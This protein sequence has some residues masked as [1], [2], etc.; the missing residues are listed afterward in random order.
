MQLVSCPRRLP[1]LLE[2]EWERMAW[3]CPSKPSYT[4]HYSVY[5]MLLVWASSIP[6]E[7]MPPAAVIN[8]EHA[9][10]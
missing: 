7:V 9:W 3:I 1:V 4:P 8:L 6:G 5:T 10:T 2:I